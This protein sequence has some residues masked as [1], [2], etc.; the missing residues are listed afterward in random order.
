MKFAQSRSVRGDPTRTPFVEL[1]QR[2]SNTG[3]AQLDW[4]DLDLIS[5]SVS[6]FRSPVEKC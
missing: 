5:C 2:W 1:E 6:T 4:R 3:E